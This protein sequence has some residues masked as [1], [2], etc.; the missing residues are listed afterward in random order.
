MKITNI[1]NHIDVNKLNI[2]IKHCIYW[3]NEKFL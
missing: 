3:D 2:S 1:L